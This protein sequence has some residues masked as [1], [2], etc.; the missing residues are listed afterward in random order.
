MND[1]N[2]SIQCSVNQC[3]Y[4][5]ESKNNCT[6]GTIKVGTHEQNPTM[7]QC[8]DCESFKVKGAM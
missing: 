8:T 3:Q 7:P 6:L 5:A 1:A 4:H 2:T